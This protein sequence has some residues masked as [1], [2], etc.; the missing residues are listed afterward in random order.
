MARRVAL[1]ASLAGALLVL[2]LV[3]LPFLR[4][5]RVLPASIPQPRPL[6]ATSIVPLEGGQRACLRRVA[7]DDRSEVA[8]IRVGTR[9]RPGVPLSLSVLGDG[10]RAGARHPPSY[11][12]NDTVTF[13]I[14]PPATPRRVVICVGN[15]GRRPV[16]LY[17]AEDRTRTRAE[18]LVDGRRAGPNFEI[19]FA[20]RRTSSFASRF[21]TTAHRLS[22]F[23]PGGPWLPWALAFLMI[24]GVPLALAVAL[25]RSAA[26]D[27]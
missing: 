3:V 5:P 15:E 11:R 24:A 23:R 21:A 17:A 14:E 10:Y 6:L 20:E 8:S 9:R 7:I 18:T 13:A 19:A 12:D 2:V 22:T 25:H 27:E 16:D 4:E 1:G 26:H